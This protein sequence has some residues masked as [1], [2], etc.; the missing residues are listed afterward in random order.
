[1][2]TRV[3]GVCFFD[4]V[5]GV[6]TGTFQ[7]STSRESIA[8]CLESAVKASGGPL[9]GDGRVVAVRLVVDEE[10]TAKLPPPTFQKMAADVVGDL[11]EVAGAKPSNLFPPIRHIA[12]DR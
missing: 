11:V 10:S 3:D 8:A 5:I 7:D 1:M 6:W 2:A 4:S 12:R 9:P